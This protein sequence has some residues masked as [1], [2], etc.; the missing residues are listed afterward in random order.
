MLN[1]FPSRSVAGRRSARSVSTWW[2]I[3]TSLASPVTSS[4]PIP[5]SVGRAITNR[6]ASCSRCR[7]RTAAA[8]MRTTVRSARAFHARGESESHGPVTGDGEHAG[9]HLAGVRGAQACRWPRR[10][11]WRGSGPTGRPRVRRGWPG[12]TVVSRCASHTSCARRARRDP[13]HRLQLTLEGGIDDVIVRRGARIRGPEASSA[14][15]SARHPVRQLRDQ[16]QPPCFRRRDRHRLC[17]ICA[18]SACHI[19]GEITFEHVFESSRSERQKP[20]V[21]KG[22]P[23]IFVLPR[24]SPTA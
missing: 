7:R 14:T 3:A 17:R 24:A 16:P 12:S 23:T 5:K 6:S 13:E 20:F 11:P 21:H 4:S 8:S 18:T 2:A 9:F 22:F 15:A 1:R 19:R 10:G